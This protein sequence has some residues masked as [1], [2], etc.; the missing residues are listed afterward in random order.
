VERISA[1]LIESELFGHVRELSPERIM[2]RKGLLEEATGGTIFLDEI[3]ETLPMFQ[4]KLLRALQEGE[5]RK[6]GSNYVNKI[7]VRVIAAT[8][9]DIYQE[10]DDGRFRV[11]LF[12]RLNSYIIEIPSLKERAE[13][14]LPLVEHFALAPAG[15]FVFQSR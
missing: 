7:D 5:I 4:V 9:R 1:Q 11:D 13:D 10:V 2:N 15:R 8:N 12:Y 3:T 14:I 6:V